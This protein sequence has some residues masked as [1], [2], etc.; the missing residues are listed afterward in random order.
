ME[1]EK[2]RLIS[3]G[4]DELAQNII[5]TSVIQGDGAGYD[6]KSFNE[7]GS[8]RYIEVKTTMGPLSTDFYMSPN[9][10]KFSEQHV[11]DFYLYRVYDMGNES[12]EAKLYLLEG[13]V[14]QKLNAT[15]VNYKMSFKG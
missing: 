12:G 1:Y 13:D 8:V 6:I 5:H 7:D 2:N 14:Q 15:P 9:E 10:I 4:H 3:F 11:N